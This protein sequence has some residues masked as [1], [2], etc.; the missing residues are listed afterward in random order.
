MRVKKVKHYICPRACGKTTFA[1][2]LQKE[3]PS[4]LLIQGEG[5]SMSID[6]L[7]TRFRGQK[8]SHDCYTGI[9]VDEFL[10]MTRHH[11]YSRSKF[12]F[13][14]EY[15]GID[16]V[17]L[18]STPDKLYNSSEFDELEMKDR[19]LLSSNN[20]EVEVI[21]TNFNNSRDI[22]SRD[23]F[24]HEFFETQILGNYRKDENKN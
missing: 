12:L 24:N 21:K 8:D 11:N 17:I 10:P 22:A 5:S 19:F 13:F 3:D 14:L 18:I 6:S 7:L 20:I 16:E 2:K 15:L 1:N 9:I 23:L 4:L